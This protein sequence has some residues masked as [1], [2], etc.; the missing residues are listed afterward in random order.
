MVQ[1]LTIAGIPPYQR[2]IK[3]VVEVSIAR[4]ITEYSSSLEMDAR[5]G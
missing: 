5:R 2:G 3:G 4:L 1:T